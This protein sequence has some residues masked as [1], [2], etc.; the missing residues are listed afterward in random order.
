MSTL[1]GDTDALA[2]RFFDAIARGDIDTVRGCYDAAA[3]I[4]HNVGGVEQEVEA[5]LRLLTWIT[6]NIKDYRYEDVRRQ[7]TDE[8]FVQQHVLRGTNRRGAPVEVPACVVARV[9]EGRI[10]RIDEYID[11]KHSETLFA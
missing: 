5:N 9:G 3:R 8:G 4:W 10:T 7:L 6:R 1:A 11:E 2:G